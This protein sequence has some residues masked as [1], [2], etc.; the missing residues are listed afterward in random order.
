M[1]NALPLFAL[2][3]ASVSCAGDFGASDTETGG[4]LVISVGAEPDYLLPPIITALLGRQVQDLVYYRLAELR[5]PVNTIGDAGF[6]PRLAE[7]WS[8]SDDSLSITFRLDP[9]A[10]WHDGAPVR[11]RD[12]VYTYSLYV[13]PKVGSPQSVYFANVDSLTAPDSLSAV[14][15]FGRRKSEQFYEFVHNFVPVP[16]HLLAEADPSALRASDLATRPVGNG[17][18]RF[19]RWERGARLELVADTAHWRGR[20]GLDRVI[21]TVAPDPTT[22]VTRLLAGEADLYESMR[23][24][25]IDQ[26]AQDSMLRLVPYQSMQYGFM[27]FN[28]RDQRERTRPH[29]LFG[30]RALRRAIT[31]A[32]DR[33]RL[34]RSIYDTLAHVAVGPFPRANAGDRELRQIPYDPDEARRLLDSLGWRDADGDGTRERG[35]VPLAFSI[36]TPTSSQPR[37]SAAVILQEQLRQ[38]GARV[39]L[40]AMEFNSFLAVQDARRFDA[41]LGVWQP[42]PTPSGIRQTWGGDGESNYGGYAD[43]TFDALLDSAVFAGDDEASAAYYHRA[44][45]TIIDDAAG[46]WLYEPRHFAGVHRR[47]R[48]TGMRPDAWWIGVPQ[49]SIPADE[50]IDRDRIPLV[51]R[52]E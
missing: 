47:V 41:W 4:T 35:S 16:S 15:W 23:P 37:M 44:Y 48:I 7:S 6:D 28:V 30:D 12:M 9:R 10:R 45:Q 49:W 1:R 21:W 43:P 51:A 5:A 13:D 20:P 50:R 36:L 22:A 39:T 19:V 25:N 2:L 26:A 31:M 32:I 42:D 8:W 52:H 17:P 40:D 46:V 24:D 11:A 33:E 14:V 34:V 38:V 18:Y 27:Q 29:P 3:A